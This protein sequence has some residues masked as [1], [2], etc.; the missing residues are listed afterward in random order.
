MYGQ[1]WAVATMI[2]ATADTTDHDQL[3]LHSAS[4]KGIT[5]VK[6]L[7]W[8][9]IFPSLAF[10]LVSILTAAITAIILAIIKNTLLTILIIIIGIPTWIY[11]LIS[12]SLSLIFAPRHAV[13][14]DLPAKKAFIQAYHSIHQL[15]LKMLGLGLTNFLA[16]TA[17]F[18]IAASPFIGIVLLTLWPIIKSGQFNPAMLILLIPVFLILLPLMITLSAIIRTFKFVIWYQAYQ[19]ATSQHHEAQA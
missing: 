4:L 7:I 3:S 10:V 2:Q 11:F 17:I 13:L 6:S 18:L 8:L 1:G 9:N 19:V 14:Q 15:K 16:S 12:I 5:K